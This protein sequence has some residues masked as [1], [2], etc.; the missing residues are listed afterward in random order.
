MMK[1][2]ERAV[3]YRARAS[4]AFAAAA[5]CSLDRA[6]EVHETAAARWTVLAESEEGRAAA[7]QVYLG[8]VRA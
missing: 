3:E 4:A 5:A 8:A 1:S 7:A 2:E 6:R